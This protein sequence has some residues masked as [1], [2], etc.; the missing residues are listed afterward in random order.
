FLSYRLRDE[1]RTLRMIPAGISY[2][3]LLF[4]EIAKA[5]FAVLKIVLNPKYKVRPQLVT[6]RTPLK[7]TVAQSILANS[8]TLTPGTLSVFAEGDMLTVHCLDSVFVKGIEDLTFQRRL[9]KLERTE[10]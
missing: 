7:T 9:L 10:E 2:I 6:F 4:I 3:A 8:I 5:S 1:L